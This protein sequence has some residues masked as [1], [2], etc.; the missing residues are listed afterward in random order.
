MTIRSG[1][2]LH[3]AAVAGVLG[4][5]AWLSPLPDR[6]TDRDV[7][8][9]TARQGI[10]WDC[11]DIHCFR[12]L[13][14][15]TLGALPGA[16]LAKWKTY[17]VVSNAGAAVMV[18]QLCLAFGLTTRTAWLALAAS[19]LGFGSLYTLHDVHTSDPL[20][21]LLGPL[22]T[23]E[24][25]RGRVA[26]SGALAAVG[27]L[28]KEFA[29]APLF[30][31]SACAALARRRELTLRALVAANFSVVV[32]LTLHLTLML[33][34]NY[35]YGNTPAL[36]LLSGG[37]VLPWFESQSTRGIVSALF[38]EYGACYLL[39]PVGLFLA[40]LSLQ[41]FAIVS[42]PVAAA[43]AYV[44]QPDRAL[45]NFHY[46]VLPLAAIV[47]DRVPAV[48]AWSTVASFALA[49]LRVGAQLAAAPPARFALAA[50]VILAVASVVCA[51]RAPALDSRPEIP[52]EVHQ[53]TIKQSTLGSRL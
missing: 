10:V 27:V 32:W 4:C 53:S 7:Y 49:N 8:E 18:F 25:M 41:R 48:L 24:L 51:L 22:L 11:T 14:A 38:N 21:Y 30:I 1:P 9:A 6:V 28:A 42:V 19:A 16:S 40:P 13:V 36:H 44:Q 3:F 46:L 31:F 47:L 34:F 5:V 35:G 12:V 39:A 15:W 2:L 23:H 33:R 20:M 52:V 29:A 17:A 50:S 45:W 37:F 26:I 43:F